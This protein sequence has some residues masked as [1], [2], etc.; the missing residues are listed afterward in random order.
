[1]KKEKVKREKGSVLGENEL[2]KKD[3]K[4]VLGTVYKCLAFEDFLNSK[5]EEFENFRG[6]YEKHL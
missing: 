6:E 2:E 3:S 5:E 4:G 1:M